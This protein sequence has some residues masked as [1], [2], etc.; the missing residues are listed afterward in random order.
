MANSYELELNEII[1]LS[2]TARALR[3]NTKDLINFKPG[4]FFMVEFFLKKENGFDIKENKSE[5]QRRAFSISSSPNSQYIELTVKKTPNP[6]V[7]DYLISYTKKGERAI[8]TGPYG[9]FIFDSQLT[10]KNL[11]FLAAGSGIAPLMSILRYIDETKPQVN[12]HLIYSNKTENEI[13]WKEEIENI[14]KRNKNILFTFT[15]TQN[16]ENTLWTGKRGRINK[17]MI[18]EIISNWKQDE[19]DC[20]ICGPLEF[21]REMEEILKMEGIPNSNI[22]YEIYE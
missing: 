18:S 19:I 6:F 2:P 9:H 17:N 8:F 21:T 3:Y 20:Y 11:I 10:K 12:I 15:L 4:Q 5:K 22:K 14:S 16:E 1:K 7:S 13:L